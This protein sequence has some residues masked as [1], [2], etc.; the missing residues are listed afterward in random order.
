[1]QTTRYHER[2]RWSVFLFAVLASCNRTD[3]PN[4]SAAPTAAPVSQPTLTYVEGKT[5]FAFFASGAV[6]LTTDTR[7]CES[8]LGENGNL[9]TK[10][11]VK[12]ALEN[13][14]VQRR[15]DTARPFVRATPPRRADGG[16]RQSIG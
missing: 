11:D 14:E 10:S 2:M 12:A 9:W 6:R 5:A 15:S 7:T 16:S 1:M 13:P 8:E 3:A 4:G